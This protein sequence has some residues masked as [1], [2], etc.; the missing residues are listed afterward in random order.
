[1]K[2]LHRFFY[3]LLLPGKYNDAQAM[4]NYRNI[5]KLVASFG[6][7]GDLI[8]VHHLGKKTALSGLEVLF[9][10]EKKNE[11]IP[12]FIES[13]KVKNA[14]E[15]FLKIEGVDT[16]E[17]AKRMVPKEV[18]LPEAEFEKYAA[19]SAP[20]TWVGFH[21]IDGGMDIGEVL[22]VIN[23]PMQVLCRIDL[24]GREAL[25]PIHGETLRKIDKKNRLVYLDLPDG[26]LDIYR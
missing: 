16:R 22:E 19:K 6:L 5:G 25:I 14:Q 17:A 12:Y 23:L 1:V 24:D 18:W 9:L 4:K 11:L 21:L 13:A 15:I 8:L 2:V 7:T 26:L 20:I 10:E 3:L